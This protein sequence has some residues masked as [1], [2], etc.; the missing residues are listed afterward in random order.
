MAWASEAK[1]DGPRERER[2][3]HWFSIVPPLELAE[4]TGPKFVEQKTLLLIAKP[5]TSP[6]TGISPRLLGSPILLALKVPVDV[7]GLTLVR[8][9]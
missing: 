3:W 9:S 8:R 7:I 4:S 5:D 1:G 6:D 2:R